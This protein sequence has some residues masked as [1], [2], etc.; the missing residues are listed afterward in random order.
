MLL[1][2]LPQYSSALLFCL[3][4]QRLPVQPDN[5]KTSIWDS[6]VSSQS[7]IV[8]AEGLDYWFSFLKTARKRINK[9]QQ[10]LNSNLGAQIFLNQLKFQIHASQAYLNLSKGHACRLNVFPGPNLLGTHCPFS[11]AKSVYH[12]LWFRYVPG[13]CLIKLPDDLWKNLVTKASASLIV[14]QQPFPL[15]INR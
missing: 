13:F 10:T 6:W 1:D 7:F 4:K 12:I 15:T 14:W 11:T 9:A 5:T 2:T 3:G 8:A